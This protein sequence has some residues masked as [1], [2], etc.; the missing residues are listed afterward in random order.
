MSDGVFAAGM[1]FV[2]DSS[3]PTSRDT[4]ADTIQKNLFSA[5]EY[6]DVLMSV[7]TR[8]TEREC[9]ENRR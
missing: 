9:A 3:P 8:G 2:T 6:F 5:L 1:Q 4:V 7:S